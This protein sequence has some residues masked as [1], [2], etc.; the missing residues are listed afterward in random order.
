MIFSFRDFPNAVRTVVFACVA[1]ALAPAAVAGCSSGQPPAAG[2]TMP[3]SPPCSA[4][5]LFAAAEA[6]QHF[7]ASSPGYS[8]IIKPVA[9]GAKCDDGWAIALISHPYVGQTDGGVLFRAV[10]GRWVYHSETG[11]V[12]AE[13]VLE[14]DGVPARV[15]TVL[16][17][18]AQSESASY[19]DQ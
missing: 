7:S 10:H 2:T 13:C 6:G 3:A 18:L 5:A 16:I 4:K 9:T 11:G 15:A 17:P 12:A 8:V 1:A 19:C 14:R